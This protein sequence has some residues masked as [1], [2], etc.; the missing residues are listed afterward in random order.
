MILTHNYTEMDNEKFNTSFGFEK[1]NF[2]NLC[3][4]TDFAQDLGYDKNIT[5]SQLAEKVLNVR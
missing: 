4:L 5:L 3:N 2:A 1:S